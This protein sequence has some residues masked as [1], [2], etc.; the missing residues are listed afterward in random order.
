LKKAWNQR[1]TDFLSGA[2]RAAC[3]ECDRSLLGPGLVLDRQG[4][5]AA[6]PRF[7]ESGASP[8]QQGWQR[9]R[10]RA[11]PPFSIRQ[12]AYDGRGRPGEEVRSTW[13]RVPADSRHLTPRTDTREPRSFESWASY[14]RASR[15]IRMTETGFTKGERA[16]APA[17][18]FATPV[19]DRLASAE[20][21]CDRG[22][23]RATHPCQCQGR[24]PPGPSLGCELSF[25]LPRGCAC[26]ERHCARWEAA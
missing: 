22:L 21:S 5:A 10:A 12:R 2:T 18:I 15:C 3:R 16:P 9:S 26:G 7:G 6:A 8:S 1:G 24:R 13:L 20:L 14:A 19:T 11:R 23:A 17:I 4:A 25:A